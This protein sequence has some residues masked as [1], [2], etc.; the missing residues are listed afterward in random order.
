MLKTPVYSSSKTWLLEAM[1]EGYENIETPIRKFKTVKLKVK[2]FVGEQLE[3]NGDA[4]AWVAIDDP[5][6][7]LVKL[8]ANIKIGAVKMLLENYVAKK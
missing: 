7:P 1:P 5:Q 8:Q 3:Q 4:Y 2:T 6:R